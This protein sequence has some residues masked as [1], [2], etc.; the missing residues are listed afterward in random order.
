MRVLSSPCLEPWAQVHFVRPGAAL[1]QVELPVDFRYR[2]GVQD[3]VLIPQLVSLGE[4]LADE[5]GVDGAV[6]DDVR[7]VDALG[8]ELARHTLRQGAQRMLAAGERRKT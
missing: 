1:L 5:L 6:D 3:A 2:V 4:H 7:D 8:P